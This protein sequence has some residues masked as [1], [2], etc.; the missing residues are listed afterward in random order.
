M[1]EMDVQYLEFKEEFYYYHEET[2]WVVLEQDDDGLTTGA[3][4][5]APWVLH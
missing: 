3:E 4:V 5:S 1:E 2:W